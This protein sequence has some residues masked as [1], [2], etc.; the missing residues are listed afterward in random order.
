MPDGDLLVQGLKRNPVIVVLFVLL[1]LLVLTVAFK[2]FASETEVDLKNGVVRAE[3]ASVSSQVSDDVNDLSVE[4]EGVADD[5]AELSGSVQ[6]VETAVAVIQNDT[7]HFKEQLEAQD[8]K[9][10]RILDLLE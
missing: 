3:V 6:T 9:L 4:L 7:Q 5:V 8:E 1:D 2:V 10:N